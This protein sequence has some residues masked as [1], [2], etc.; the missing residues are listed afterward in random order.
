MS[1]LEVMSHTVENPVV[2]T[3]KGYRLI[4]VPKFIQVDGLHSWFS[5]MRINHLILLFVNFSKSLLKDMLY[6]KCRFAL[7]IDS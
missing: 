1:V 2:L 4:K 5:K 7:K 3:A 6:I